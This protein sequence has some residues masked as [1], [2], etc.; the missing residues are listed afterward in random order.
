MIH[1]DIKE[2]SLQLGGQVDLTPDGNAQNTY[3]PYMKTTRISES[4]LLLLY[5]GITSYPM[6]RI[7]SIPWRDYSVVTA[8][9]HLH[10]E[11][12]RHSHL[13]PRPVVPER[14][15]HKTLFA[16]GGQRVRELRVLRSVSLSCP[17]CSTC[18]LPMYSSGRLGIGAREWAGCRFRQRSVRR[19]GS[20][21]T[22]TA[23]FLSLVHKLGDA[24]E[25]DAS[26]KHRL[27]FSNSEQWLHSSKLI[28]SAFDQRWIKMFTVCVQ[29]MSR[30]NCAVS[31]A[32]RSDRQADA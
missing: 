7:T 5:T 21:V 14:I 32:P 31:H 20:C 9:A 26:T 2:W 8:S 4:E 13:S 27:T 30:M 6:F 10:R 16:G 22:S 11:R 3:A 18:L 24:L 25:Y 19:F 23:V 15:V 1:L 29:Y 17:L 28:H 12:K